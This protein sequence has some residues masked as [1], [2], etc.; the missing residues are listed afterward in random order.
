MPR[1]VELAGGVPLQGKA[2]R[3]PAALAARLEG[4]V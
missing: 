3:E 2:A 4:R 1:R